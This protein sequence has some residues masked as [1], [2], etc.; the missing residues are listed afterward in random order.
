MIQLGPSISLHDSFSQKDF[1]RTT[2]KIKN[3]RKNGEKKLQTQET[4]EQARMVQAS[5]FRNA[6]CSLDIRVFN[7]NE[8][9]TQSYSFAVKKMDP[10]HSKKLFCLN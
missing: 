4:A 9:W 3:E 7:I 10:R 5:L 8:K 6:C 2:E 1:L